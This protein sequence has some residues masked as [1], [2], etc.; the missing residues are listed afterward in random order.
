VLHAQLVDYLLFVPNCV[1]QGFT[2]GVAMIIAIGQYDNAFGLVFKVTVAG[3]AAA[4][5]YFRR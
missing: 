4:F 3:A 1:V 5:L 2:V